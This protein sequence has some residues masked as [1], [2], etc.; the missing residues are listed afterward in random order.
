MHLYNAYVAP[1][2]HLF[3]RNFAFHHTFSPFFGSEFSKNGA[4]TI[5]YAIFFVPLALEMSQFSL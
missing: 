3:A 1:P 2:F 5:L 4:K